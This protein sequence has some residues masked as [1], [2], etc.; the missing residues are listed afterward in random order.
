[1]RP[2]FVTSAIA[3]LLVAPALNAQQ[4]ASDGPYKVLQRARVGG[5]GGTDYIYADD[6]RPSSALHHAQCNAHPT[7]AT[8]AGPALDAMPGRISVFNLETLALIGEIFRARPATAQAS[9]IP[10]RDTASRATIPTS[11][12]ST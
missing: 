6:G 4:P 5:E 1:M 10:N 7:P 3:L 9:P 12:C 2:L 8:A 11:R